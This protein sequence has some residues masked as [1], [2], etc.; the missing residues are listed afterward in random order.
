[1][2]THPRA[3]ILLCCD[4]FGVL[5]PLSRLTPQQVQYYFI[6]GYTAKVAGTEQGIT[7]PTATFSAC[8]GAPFLVWH[9]IV[10]AE[11]LAQKL[12][13]HKS[14]A[15]LLNTGWTKGG[16]GV[17]ERIN[18]KHTRAMVDAIHNESLLGEEVEYEELPLFGLQIPKAVPNVPSGLLNPRSAWS[19]AEKYDEALNKLYELF[20][21]NFVEYA[22]RCPLE[23]RQAGPYF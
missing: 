17:G 2:G 23:V 10:Y 14:T 20:R 12:E 6:S 8:F 9:P 16:Y 7:E 3:V 11:M 5:P 21:A 22:D 19:D 13:Q 15:Y 1:M 18:L 4:A